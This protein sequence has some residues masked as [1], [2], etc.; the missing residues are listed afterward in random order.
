LDVDVL[1]KLVA[2]ALF[3][4]HVLLTAYHFPLSPHHVEPLAA[5]SSAFHL[6]LHC[7]NHVLSQWGG[8][9]LLL[10]RLMVPSDVCD[11]RRGLYLGYD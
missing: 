2:H 7:G 5:V 4:N 3:L 1:F 10:N 8:F 9:L 11:P 6:A